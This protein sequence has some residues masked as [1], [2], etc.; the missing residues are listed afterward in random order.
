MSTPYVESGLE[1]DRAAEAAAKA[2]EVSPWPGQYQA[3][4]A[5]EPA[6]QQSRLPFGMG[7]LAFSVLVAGITAIIV[8]GAV[9]GGLGGALANC[10][11]TETPTVG[12]A[13]SVETATTAE[14]APSS[15][16]TT[17][18]DS[19]FY[20]PKPAR[21]V[22]NLTLPCSEEKQ[23]STYNSPNTAYGFKISC[24]TN[25]GWNS[26]SQEGGRVVDIAAIIAYTIEDCM[27]ACAQMTR[28]DGNQK[29][30]A[31]CKSIVFNR[32]LSDSIRSEGANCWL[33]NGSKPES[34]QWGVDGWTVAY[35]Q[36]GSRN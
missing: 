34:A 35:A 13:G 17:D 18:V 31:V 12:S 22:T 28:Y 27:D 32:E 5:Y 2:P 29:T 19:A 7:V 24:Y 9:G 4:P 10:R 16:A 23:D 30:G 15:T 3:A 26:Q 1:V 14:C 8:G 36:I 20:S 33:K 21:Q 25:L 6:S 11:S